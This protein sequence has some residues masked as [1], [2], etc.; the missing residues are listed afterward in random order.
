MDNHTSKTDLEAEY[1]ILKKNYKRTIRKRAIFITG[2]L[3]LFFTIIV[4]VLFV[5]IRK[6]N[7]HKMAEHYIL[8][9]AEVQKASGGIKD[10][11]P[12]PAGSIKTSNGHGTARLNI[13][14]NGKKHDLDVYVY[15]EKEPDSEWRVLE[16]RIEE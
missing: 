16:M 9:N 7:A 14:V 6:S 11:G 13:S 10:F 3:L 8:E 5:V 12:L 1:Q 4:S 15:L 2:G